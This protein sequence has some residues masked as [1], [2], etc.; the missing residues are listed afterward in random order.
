MCPYF[1]R[2][3][4]FV[5]LLKLRRGWEQEA[6]SGSDQLSK[7]TKCGQSVFMLCLHLYHFRHQYFCTQFDSKY[8]PYELKNPL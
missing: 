1:P 6:E 4:P 8:C 3:S 7:M 2:E 5:L